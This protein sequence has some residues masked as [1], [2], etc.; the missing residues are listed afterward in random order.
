MDIQYIVTTLVSKYDDLVIHNTY[1]E[2]AIMLNPGNKLAK[3]KYFCTLKDY[4]GP[5][6]KASNLDRDKDTFRLNL[7]ISKQRF[8]ELFVQDK[9]PSRP[10]KGGIVFFQD[11]EI[12]FKKR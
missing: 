10:P 8:L 12:D 1:G 2:T 6:D 4:D 3:G 7:K 11:F 5:N 9:L